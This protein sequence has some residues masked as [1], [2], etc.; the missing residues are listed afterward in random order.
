ML[1]GFFNFIDGIIAIE[2]SSY[3]T[4]RLIFGNFTAWGW[5]MLI[6]GIIQ[7]LVGVGVFAGSDAAALLGILFALLNAI[8]QLLFLRAYPVWSIIMIALDVLVVYALLAH[9]FGAHTDRAYEGR[10]DPPGAYAQL[11]DTRGWSQPGA[12][13][14]GVEYQRPADPS[15]GY[16]QPEHR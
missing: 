1:V 4:N 9:G 16:Q 11:A 14:A 6:L 2:K 5:T 7:V 15:G 13:G 10:T 8:G 12:A 3:L